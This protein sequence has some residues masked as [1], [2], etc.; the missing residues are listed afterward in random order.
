VFLISIE[1]SEEIRHMAKLTQSFIATWCLLKEGVDKLCS[2]IWNWKILKCSFF[3]LFSQQF[4]WVIWVKYLDESLKIIWHVD[5]LGGTK[6]DTVKN[7]IM[8]FSTM[9]LFATLSI[10][11]L[12]HMLIVVFNS[13]LCWLS[14]CWMS[15]RQSFMYPWFQLEQGV[16]NIFS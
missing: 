15:W 16:M 6:F 4:C 3:V 5:K 14:L 1:T 13:L 9:C 8:T 12:Y 11:A 10:T 7:S 2:H